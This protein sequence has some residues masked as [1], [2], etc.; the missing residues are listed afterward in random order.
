ML[1]IKSFVGFVGFSALGIERFV[2]LLVER[3]FRSR[4]QH[5]TVVV[6]FEKRFVVSLVVRLYQLQFYL[7][8]FVGCCLPLFITSTKF[9]ITK[10]R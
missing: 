8:G 1:L 5:H 2:V 9:K 10:R 6:G 7:L 4:T 3:L